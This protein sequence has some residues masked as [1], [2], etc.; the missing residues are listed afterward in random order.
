VI[1]VAP[2][3]FAVTSWPFLEYVGR[4][5]AAILLLAASTVYLAA[6][7][8][9]DSRRESGDAWQPLTAAAT[10]FAS[11]AIERAVGSDN[12]SLAWLLE[13]AVLVALGTGPRGAWL[14][15]LGAAVSLMGGCVH[16]VRLFGHEGRWNDTLA[17]VHAESLRGLGGIALL[18]VTA[19]LLH[20]EQRFG[21]DM[22]LLLSR[23]WMA[24][25]ML[26]L[27]LWGAQE[28]NHLAR[29]LEGGGVRWRQLTG[30]ERVAIESKVTMVRAFTTSALW[31][32]Q[33]MALVAAGWRRK[34]SFL[35]WLGLALVGLTVAKFVFADLAEVDLFWRFTSAMMVGV[36]LM[37]VSFFYQR[38]MKKG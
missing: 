20:R 17:F 34:S 28:S 5:P 9:I 11:V 16:L 14:R 13:G 19:A 31:T 8:W 12:L 38:R 2:L 7:W 22:R 15:G 3:L 25:A 27:M 36:V 35:R 29:A 10:L 32:L 33:A 23:A 24:V 26:M 4:M 18:V 1:T 30:P 37:G 6:A 21:Q